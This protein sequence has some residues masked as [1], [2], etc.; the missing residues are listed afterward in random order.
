MILVA[1]TCAGIQLETICA[2]VAMSAGRS[3]TTA[4]LGKRVPQKICDGQGLLV[5]R[6]RG[7]SVRGSFVG[8]RPN[9]PKGDV[10]VLL[11]S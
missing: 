2:S 8:A 11:A 7:G 5:G 1:S 6:W 9:R 3:N 4:K 10:F